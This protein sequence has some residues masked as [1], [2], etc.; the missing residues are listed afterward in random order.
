[1]SQCEYVNVIIKIYVRNKGCNFE[2]VHTFEQALREYINNELVV[3]FKSKFSKP[4]LTTR[5]SLIESDVA[6][7]YTTEIFK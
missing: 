5:P 6:K 4:V 2:F 3:Y 7:T 1:M